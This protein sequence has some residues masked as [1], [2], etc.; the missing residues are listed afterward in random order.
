MVQAGQE[1]RRPALHSGVPGHQV[2]D[3]RPL[4]MAE[5][6]R[7]GD[8]WRWLDDHEWRLRPVGARALA[9]GIEDV[10]RRPSAGRWRV[11]PRLVGRPS[12]FPLLQPR[13]SGR[14]PRFRVLAPSAIVRS[15]NEEPARP[16]DERVVVPPAGSAPPGGRSSRPQS[17]A[18][19]S[20]RAIGRLPHDSRATF[21]PL[22]LGAL[23][24]AAGRGP[25]S[26][27]RLATLLLSVNAVKAPIVAQ[28]AAASASHSILLPRT[29]RRG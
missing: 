24:H 11:R 15:V 10:R 20:R 22:R 16:A 6:Q 29:S 12:P 21:T 26:C 8:V 7:A 14:P 17:L 27:H 28:G 5:V 18:M 4:G 9:V 13:R 2:L 23:S 3:S 25:F 1:E 19:P